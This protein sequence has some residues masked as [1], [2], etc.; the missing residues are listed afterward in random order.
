MCVLVLTR[1]SVEAP[2]TE[3]LR[4]TM[5]KVTQ[6]IPW[7]LVVSRKQDEMR[8]DRLLLTGVLIQQ[9]MR[10]STQKQK[11]GKVT[12]CIGAV[13]LGMS[14]LVLM[15]RCPSKEDAG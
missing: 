3:T 12:E 9:R 13:A 4:Q 8:K 2:E 11:P 10:R 6:S 1:E 7:Q 15:H 5:I 14:P